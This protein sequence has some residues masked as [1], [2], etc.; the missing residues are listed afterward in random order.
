MSALDP[1]ERFRQIVKESGEHA[2]LADGPVSPDA[3]LLDLCAEALH[4]L[5]SAEK[6]EVG[7]Y[8]PNGN[9]SSHTPEEREE[10]RGRQAEVGKLR[11][12]GA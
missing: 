4:F 5:V 2:L 10:D 7:I 12:K 11:K 1:I 8:I 6:V 3:D 9:D